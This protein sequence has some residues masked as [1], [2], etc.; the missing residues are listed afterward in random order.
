RVTVPLLRLDTETTLS[1]SFSIVE[2][3]AISP[4][5][6]PLRTTPP[7]VLPLIVV[8]GPTVAELTPVPRT[9]TPL[10]PVA[11]TRRA[12]APFA[13]ALASPAEL[14][15]TGVVLPAATRFGWFGTLRPSGW[16][17]SF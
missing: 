2:P 15:I 14:V 11:L 8:F 4:P 17:T 6:A 1:L 10:A 3:I 16:P 5:A 13:R 12:S 9:P 7:P